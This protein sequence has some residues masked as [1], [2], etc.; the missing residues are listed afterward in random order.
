V[1]H[2]IGGYLKVDGLSANHQGTKIT[3]FHQEKKEA[4]LVFLCALGA[5]VVKHLIC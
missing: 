3:K 4:S 5:L 2:G 1:I